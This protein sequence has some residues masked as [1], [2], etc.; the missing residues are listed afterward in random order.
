[1]LLWPKKFNARFPASLLGLV[2]ATAAAWIFG[3][4]IPVI[5][6]IPQKL[7]RADRLQFTEI[8]W[9]NLSSFV[10]PA[11]TITALSAVE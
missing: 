2:L 5:G 3:W 1:M 11:I 8:P 4:S 9:T 7:L 6:E 10:A